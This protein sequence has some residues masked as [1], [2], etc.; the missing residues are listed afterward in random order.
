MALKRGKKRTEFKEL[1]EQAGLTLTEATELLKVDRRTTY[2][3]ERGETKPRRETQEI[4]ANGTPNGPASNSSSAGDSLSWEMAI[5][6]TERSRF[7]LR[8]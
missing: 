6:I 1:R 3:Y 7:G 8:R 2:R 5:L 4:R